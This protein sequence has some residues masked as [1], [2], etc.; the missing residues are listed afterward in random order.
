MNAPLNIHFFTLHPD[1]VEYGTQNYVKTEIANTNYGHCHFLFIFGACLN[2]LS[3]LQGED[4]YQSNI[5]IPPPT[6]NMLIIEMKIV[7]IFWAFGLI[8]F[9]HMFFY[10]PFLDPHLITHTSNIGV[11]S[12]QGIYLGPLTLIFIL[13]LKTYAYQLWYETWNLNCPWSHNCLLNQRLILCDIELIMF[14]I[15]SH[16]LLIINLGPYVMLMLNIIF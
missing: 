6:N 3:W 14:I 1:P 5:F 4:S 15:G 2:I 10:C 9:K 11:R 13:P 7:N 12:W 16:I 8:S